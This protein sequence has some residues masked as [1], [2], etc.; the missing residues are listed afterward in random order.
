[1][2]RVLTCVAIL[3][4]AAATP[5]LADPTPQTQPQAASNPQDRVICEREQ[6]TGSR[7]TAHKICH[8]A[9]EWAQIQR[10]DRQDLERRQSDRPMNG[11]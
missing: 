10:D 7:L 9:S 3:A 4:F 6:D 8:T 11:H 2:S 1:V 5:A